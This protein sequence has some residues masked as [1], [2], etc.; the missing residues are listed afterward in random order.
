MLNF[1]ENPKLLVYKCTRDI[2]QGILDAEQ[3]AALE[4]ELSGLRKR[5]LVF[6][7]DSNERLQILLLGHLTGV[8]NTLSATCVLPR[9]EEEARRMKIK[10]VSDIRIKAT[11]GIPAGVGLDV[12]SLL[13]IAVQNHSDRPFHYDAL[14]LELDDGKTMVPI[15]DAFHRPLPGISVVDSGASLSLYLDFSDLI[16]AA[17]DAGSAIKSVLVRDQ[18]GREFRSSEGELEIALANFMKWEKWEMGKWG[19][20]T[21]SN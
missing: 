1:K 7:Y 8:A 20:A 9:S 13:C 5:S 19:R 18:I 12:Q 4:R 11:W 21:G 15:S 10:N 2:P 17:A 3:I 6:E 14:V 16:K